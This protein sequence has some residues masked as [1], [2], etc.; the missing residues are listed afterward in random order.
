MTNEQLT[1]LLTAN[2]VDKLIQALKVGKP[3]FSLDTARKQF[4]V[5]GHAVM[6]KA[7]RRDKLVETEEG[8][9]VEP[10]NRIAISLQELICERAVSF[11]FGTPV[12]IQCEPEGDQQVLIL[13]AINRI[14]KDNKMDSFSAE[15]ALELFRST[16]VA[17]RWFVSPTAEPYK[18]YGF[19][20]KSKLKCM[21]FSPWNGDVLYPLFSDTGDMIAFSREYVVPEEGKNVTYFETY[22]ADLIQAWKKSGLGWEVVQR[23]KNVIGKIPIVYAA[24]PE[25]EWASVQNI[26]ERIEKQLSNYADTTD[27][28]ASP[29]LFG[30]GDIDVFP[31]K[32]EPGKLIIGK[33][34]ATLEYVSLDQ[35]PEMVKFEYDTLLSLIYALSQT[36]NISFEAMKGLG[37]ISGVAFDRLFVDA[38]LKVKKKRRI[39][40][41][42]LE[43]RTNLI[44]SFLS[45][46]K[47]DLAEACSVIDI[48]TVV[49]P[50]TFEDQKENVDTL[51]SAVSG[52]I[53][54]KKTAVKLSGLVDDVEKEFEQITSEEE[55]ANTLNIAPPAL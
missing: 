17:E 12:K 52:G 26:I 39:F 42:Y 54:S 47:T 2:E 18:R 45:Y 3:E 38:K 48:D 50:F 40:D 1:A 23:V 20:A 14:L 33:G 15:V 29:T 11:L 31:K 21:M 32:G 6:D 53:L 34:D 9:R 19:L 46:I 13:K 8:P 36:P 35:A 41:A 4:S 43:R 27:Y 30:K 10:V 25:V 44:L 28:H 55:A 49:Q 51:T 24:Q 7:H 5:S 16:E 37:D 22:T